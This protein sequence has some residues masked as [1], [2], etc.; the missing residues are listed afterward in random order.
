MCSWLTVNTQQ[1]HVLTRRPHFGPFWSFHLLFCHTHLPTAAKLHCTE[2]NKKK[3]ITEVAFFPPTCSVKSIT[4]YLFILRSKKLLFPLWG[5]YFVYVGTVRTRA[6]WF[7]PTVFITHLC[8]SVTPSDSLRIWLHF[9]TSLRSS[10]TFEFYCCFNSAVTICGFWS[11][12][13]FSSS[14]IC[15]I[16][17]KM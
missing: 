11:F 4:F 6:C 12:E 15:H 3:R 8:R 9:P 2:V 17:C 13:Y 16:Y 1:L 5:I 14:G 10:D 7:K